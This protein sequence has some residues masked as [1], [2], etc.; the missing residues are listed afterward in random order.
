[1]KASGLLSSS[2]TEGSGTETPSTNCK[3]GGEG[4]SVSDNGS[5][6]EEPAEDTSNDEE[7]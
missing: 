7:E 1:V 4:S 5:E 2:D 6:R 3:N